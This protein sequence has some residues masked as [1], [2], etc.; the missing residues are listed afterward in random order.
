MW[1]VGSMHRFH[2]RCWAGS[3]VVVVLQGVIW[4]LNHISLSSCLSLNF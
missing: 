1:I 2:S 4:V 3:R